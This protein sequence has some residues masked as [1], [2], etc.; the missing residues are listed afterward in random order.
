MSVFRFPDPPC[1]LAIF[2]LFLFFMEARASLCTVRDLAGN[3]PGAR[4]LC[5]LCA[6]L[7]L[8]ALP[9]V[10]NPKDATSHSQKITHLAVSSSRDREARCFL[11]SRKPSAR[12]KRQGAC[13]ALC[14]S[15]CLSW[16]KRIISYSSGYTGQSIKSEGKG[17][18]GWVAS[19]PAST[20]NRYAA[21]L[22]DPHA[23]V[24]HDRQD[25]PILSKSP[26]ER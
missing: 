20:P 5:S 13:A 1:P 17:A 10:R 14:L 22:L 18:E 25:S 12:P 24:I 8:R 16:K 11:C 2:S 7:Y 9:F 23:Q 15:G 4:G 3:P 19:R 6:A 26:S 21:A